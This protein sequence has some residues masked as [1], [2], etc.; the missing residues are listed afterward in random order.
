MPGWLAWLIGALVVLIP[1]VAAVVALGVI[2]GGRRPSTGMAWLILILAVPYLGIVAFLLLGS[3]SVGKRRRAWQAEVNADVLAARRDAGR[4]GAPD[5]RPATGPGTTTQVRA[6]ARLNQNLGA[7]P[8]LGGNTVAVFSD[9]RESIEAMT[10]EAARAERFVHVE[11]YISAWDEVT[12]AFFTAL[13]D[14]AERGVEVRLLFD[15]LG[16]R[17]IPVYKDFLK[18]LRGTRIVWAAMLP[19][20]PLKGQFRRPDLRN[21]RKILVV[22]GRVGFV[23]SL[24]MIEPGYDKPKNHKRGL[25]WVELVTRVTGPAV[26]E[27]GVVFATDWAAETREVVRDTLGEGETDPSL[28]G[29]ADVAC[30]VVPSGPGFVTENNLRL[31][32]SLLYGARSRVA[33]TS[34]YFVPDETLL[35]AVTTAAQRGVQVELFVSAVADQFMVF[36]AQRSYYAALLEAGVRIW[37][38]PEPYVLHAKFFTIDDDLAVIGSSNMDYRSFA[39]NYEVVLLVADPGVVARLGEVHQRYRELSTELT[40]EAWAQRGRRAAYVDNVM[41][42]TATLQ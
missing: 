20:H 18:R 32:N 36:H 21:H 3:N 35:Y 28:S 9:Y 12:D 26:R 23:G 34:P 6:L 29:V 30:Q 8:M 31:F 38:Y 27:L 10:A 14:A 19:L 13:A 5:L 25:S 11:F 41:R 17:G 37:L 15:H 4:S 42:L 1:V 39:L 22:D 24:N 7:L 16:S 2:P 40:A 33:L